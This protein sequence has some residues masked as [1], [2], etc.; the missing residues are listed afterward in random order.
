MEGYFHPVTTVPWMLGMD[1]LCEKA[2]EFAK[3]QANKG[4]SG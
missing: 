3:I 1:F 2:N 4:K